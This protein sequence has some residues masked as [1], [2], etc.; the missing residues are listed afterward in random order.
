MLSYRGVLVIT[1]PFLLADEER[2]DDDGLS[3]FSFFVQ[4]MRCDE[5]RWEGCLDAFPLSK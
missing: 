3:L 4:P 2:D 1:I 5:M